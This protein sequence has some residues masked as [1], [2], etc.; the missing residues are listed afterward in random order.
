MNPI[1]TFA[2]AAA[3]VLGGWTAF[4]LAST[5]TA[6]DHAASEAA[7]PVTPPIAP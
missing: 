3:L 2:A 6:P 5:H 4:S 1:F 7:A